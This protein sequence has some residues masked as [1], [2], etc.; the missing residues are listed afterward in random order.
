MTTKKASPA[1]HNLTPIEVHF[2]DNNNPTRALTESV[3]SISV[4]VEDRQT[5]TKFE[6]VSWGRFVSR[7][8]RIF[9][10]NTNDSTAGGL[11]Q[12]KILTL[13]VIYIRDSITPVVSIPGELQGQKKIKLLEEFET[14]S[15][16]I[17]ES[18][19]CLGWALSK[20]GYKISPD[21]PGVDRPETV[22]R[23][24]DEGFRWLRGGES[25][26]RL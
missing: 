15:K 5:G 7:V 21:L 8:E 3:A 18:Y 22:T 2:N 24:M 12:W 17:R 25:S 23:F 1:Y 16:N 11:Q 9:P 6:I 14:E 13:E 26:S 4:R 19:R 10:K 20:R